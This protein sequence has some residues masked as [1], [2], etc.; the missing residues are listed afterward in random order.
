[1][2]LKW[3]KKCIERGGGGIVKKKSISDAL[4]PPNPAKTGEIW[5]K[6]GTNL[7]QIWFGGLRGKMCIDIM[8]HST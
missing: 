6:I 1:M 7:V 8:T 4:S 3:G 5:S 2:Y